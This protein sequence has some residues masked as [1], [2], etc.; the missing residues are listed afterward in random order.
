MRIAP[1]LI[2][3]GEPTAVRTLAL[4]GGVAPETLER[5]T[6]RALGTEGFHQVGGEILGYRAVNRTYF[7]FC[8]HCI[9]EDLDTFAGPTRGRPWLRLQWTI[10]H[11]RSCDRHNVQMV[12][13]SPVRRRFE[14]FDFS[15]AVEGYLKDPGSGEVAIEPA[16]SSAF[17]SWMLRRLDGYREE[18]NWLD[19]LP[20]YVAAE[21]C[22][23]LG[24]SAL[25]HPK[26]R[27]S[28]L[29]QAGW[30]KA[31]NE[32]YRI[33]SGGIGAV[34]ELLGQLND[35]QKKTRG[36]WGLRDTYGYAYGLLQKTVTEPDF[37]ALRDVV[38]EYA[39]ATVP[40]PPNTDVLGVRTTETAIFTVRS[41]ASA[42]GAHDRTIRRIIEREQLSENA[43]EAGLRNHRV[44]VDAKDIDTIVSKL[45]D[46]MT[47]P[48]VRAYLGGLYRPHLEALIAVGALPTIGGAEKQAYAKRKFAR[49]DVEAMVA[50]ALEG[51]SEV[52]EPTS[53]QMTI[54]DARHAAVTDH[55]TI[56][57]LVF[58]GKLKW[59]G[60]LAG[61]SD[62]GALL[63]DADE[64][65]SLVRSEGPLTNHRRADVK[66]L[67]RFGPST[68][69]TLIDEGVL[70]ETAEFSADARREV[71]V[72]TRSSVDALREKYVALGE[73]RT[74][75]GLHVKQVKLLLKG[76]R[77]APA[78]DPSKFGVFLYDRQAVD[79]VLRENPRFWA[80]DKATAQARVT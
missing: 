61:R 5:Y 29:T 9:A 78:L 53:R 41:A 30:S 71:A 1:R 75:S 26:V 69:Q 34:R 74:V 40:I 14:P 13:A 2:D 50:R 19:E 70:F 64:I 15:E 55:E 18:S 31:A 52:S 60:R 37:A 39:V 38:R 43:I 23:A 46:H 58:Q 16:P 63:V 11:F 51:A 65:V 79:A 17:Q 48:A 25:W 36:F 62:Y 54:G 6:P 32:G 49:S 7:S 3:K 35:A 56:L 21:W 68:I 57:A 80:Y 42:S 44:M 73:L 8:P 24:V 10:R 67:L 77:I 72:V 66:A 27:A 28:Q 12:A 45:K 76:V 4:V 20:L 59:K 47:G 22:E 33:A